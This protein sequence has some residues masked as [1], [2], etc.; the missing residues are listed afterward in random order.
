LPIVEGGRPVI[1]AITTGPACV[2]WRIAMISRSSSAD[3]RRG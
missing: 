1:A 3:K 2:R